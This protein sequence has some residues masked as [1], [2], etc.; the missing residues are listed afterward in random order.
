MSRY[1]VGRLKRLKKL[2]IATKLL[3]QEKAELKFLRK[4]KSKLSKW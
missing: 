4:H 3:P 2:K 1:L